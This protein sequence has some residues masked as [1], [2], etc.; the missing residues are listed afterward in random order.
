MI[1][2][3]NLAPARIGIGAPSGPRRVEQPGIVQG[4]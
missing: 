4:A 2:S 3:I 1:G